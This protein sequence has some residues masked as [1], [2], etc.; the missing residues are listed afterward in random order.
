MQGDKLEALKA[1]VLAILDE[2][3]ATGQCVEDVEEAF[4]ASPSRPSPSLPAPVETGLFDRCPSPSP[5]EDLRLKSD[6]F[7]AGFMAATQYNW[8]RAE[9]MEEDYRENA[10]TEW[11]TT[12]PRPT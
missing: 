5:E 1:R 2:N 11:L 3:N 8:E 10:L 7:R 9:G 12:P 6:A 4:A